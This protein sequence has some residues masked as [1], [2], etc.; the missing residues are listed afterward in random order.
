MP[1][2]IPIYDYA[3]H[4]HTH[5]QTY[6]HTHE[7]IEEKHIYW[8]LY[9]PSN[10]LNSC[11]LCI[12]GNT[13]S[14]QRLIMYSSHPTLPFHAFP[15]LNKAVNKNLY[16]FIDWHFVKSR[17]PAIPLPEAMV[18]NSG[19][20]RKGKSLG[21]SKHVKHQ[22][23]LTTDSLFLSLPLPS[24]LT[25]PPWELLCFR[26]SSWLCPWFRLEL[27]LSLKVNVLYFFHNINLNALGPHLLKALSITTLSPPG[28]DCCLSPNS[29]SSKGFP[30][31]TQ[32][33]FCEPEQ[34]TLL[35]FS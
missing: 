19:A 15:S 3:L 2:K 34:N 31:V 27:D 7:W 10:E 8:Q 21:L 35:D 9:P 13:R 14:S 26:A 29:L 28:P 23:L 11:V 1:Y 17:V 4:R 5:T 12:L 32:Y 20:V 16:T 6:T 24:V 22:Q 18:V 25:P 33:H 30:C